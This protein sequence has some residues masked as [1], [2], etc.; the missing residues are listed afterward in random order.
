[1]YS[2]VT[3]AALAE[4]DITNTAAVATAVSQYPSI[5]FN[6]LSLFA[7]VGEISHT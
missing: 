6:S 2:K 7:P 3:V 1:M 5:R 4:A